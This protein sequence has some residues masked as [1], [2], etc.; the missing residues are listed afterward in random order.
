MN[1]KKNLVLILLMVLIMPMIYAE[2]FDAEKID[3]YVELEKLYTG[4]QVQEI[5]L[6][7]IQTANEEMERTVEDAIK[8][9]V[10][11]FL[12]EREAFKSLLLDMGNILFSADAEIGRLK[13]R[14][15]QDDLG[16]GAVGF[17]VGVIAGILIVIGLQNL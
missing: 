7:M 8:E 14:K 10:I 11:P 1:W 13:K 2:L 3:F 15:F 9:V 4:Y 5:I 17:V 16:A 12:G 6:G